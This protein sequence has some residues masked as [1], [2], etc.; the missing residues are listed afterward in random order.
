MLAYTSLP[1]GSR[2]LL[3]AIGRAGT[4]ALA[5]VLASMLL[6]AAALSLAVVLSLAGMLGE[7]LLAIFS[8][9]TS[10]SRRDACVTGEGLSIETDSGAAQEARESCGQ[11]EVAYGVGLHEEFPFFGWA[12]C[13]HL[14][15]WGHDPEAGRA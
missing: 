3:G 14:E 10:D 13:F 8:H 4:L 15:V 9:R 6:V 5:V 11:C 12:R 1:R 2:L 7:R